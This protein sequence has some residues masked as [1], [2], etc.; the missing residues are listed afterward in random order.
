MGK[1][2]EMNWEDYRYFLALADTGSFSAA[3]RERGVDHSTV[4]RRVN[5]LE[6]TFGVRLID[7]LPKSVMLT[8]DG[9]LV[10]EQ[11]RQAVLAMQAV[12]R[13]AAGSADHVSGTVCVSAPPAL[14][15]HIIG[16]KVRELREQHPEIDLVLQGETRS[17]DLNRRQADIA[18]RL[19]R[20]EKSAVTV[21]KLTDMPF[22][23][24]SAP[25]YDKPEHVWDF[26]NWDETTASI[27]QHR[28][29]EERL[30]GRKVVLRSNDTSIQ[31]AAAGSGLGV[32]IL[33]HFVGDADPRLARLYPHESFP[34]REVWMLVHEDLRDAPRIRTVMDFLIKTVAVLKTQIV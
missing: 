1:N 32:A 9:K 4:A 3:A 2:A 27:P 10:A 8:V 28:W 5:A 17:T 6:T 11:G 33:P 15:S 23:F 31:A 25:D 19:S 16:P 22:G 29:I 12:E 21:R 18:L 34:P 30:H 20:P 7:R 14:A 13:V 26:I 24:Y